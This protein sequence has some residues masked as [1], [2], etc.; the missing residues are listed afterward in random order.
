MQENALKGI[1]HQPLKVKSCKTTIHRDS[2]LWQRNLKYEIA[3]PSSYP[4]WQ[5]E[6]TMAF[7]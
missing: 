4:F 5:K 6:K 7:R 2:I 3:L 1:G